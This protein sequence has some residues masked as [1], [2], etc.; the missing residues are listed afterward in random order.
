MIQPN[1]IRASTFQAE[2]RQVHNLL[3]T[4]RPGPGGV[5]VRVRGGTQ[6]GA[7]RPGSAFLSGPSGSNTV[8]TLACYSLPATRATSHPGRMAGSILSLRLRPTAVR[9]S[10]CEH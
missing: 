3:N 1:S 7:V 10:R 6:A 4:G 2:A 5:T 8:P 9:Q